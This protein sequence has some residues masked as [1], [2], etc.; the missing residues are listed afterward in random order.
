TI[1]LVAPPSAES[2]FHSITLC[3]RSPSP[4]VIRFF[5]YTQARTQDTERPRSFP[6]VPLL[7]V[8]IDLVNTSCLQT[9]KLRAP[10]NTGFSCK[11]SPLGTAVG[12][13][14]A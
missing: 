14:P 9:P 10:W 8:L 4:R 5:W 11:H 2:C 1:S 12:W 13:E 3:T 6:Q 7:E